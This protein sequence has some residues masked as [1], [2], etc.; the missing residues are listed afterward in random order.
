MEYSKNTDGHGMNIEM[1][2]STEDDTFAVLRKPTHEG[3]RHIM[4][5][6]WT[7]YWDRPV[8]GDNGWLNH[9]NEACK[10]YGWTYREYMDGF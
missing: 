4:H 3:M 7:K 2:A 1:C 8:A 9:A 5:D 6:V 10:E